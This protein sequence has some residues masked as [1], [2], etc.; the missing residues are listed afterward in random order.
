[1]LPDN[2][3]FQ[4]LKRLYDLGFS[5]SGMLDIGAY[6]GDFSRSARKI[7]PNSHIL[8]VEALAEKEKSL[9]KTCH[10]LGNADYAIALLGDEGRS[11]TS[12]FVVDVPNGVK[13]G[14][15]KFK[16]NNNY[17]LIERHLNQVTLQTLL[18]SRTTIFQFI[19]ID[20]QGAELD[21][22]KG[23]GHYLSTIDVILIELSLVNYNDGA[24]LIAKVLG[25]LDQMGFALFDLVEEHRFS[26]YL[27]QIDGLFLRPNCR[28]RPQPPFFG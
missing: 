22:L 18:N 8:M 27:F 26:G 19:K 12:F 6:D 20:V 15:S 24:P 23:M 21:V 7:F 4:S 11:A 17:P 25:V 10:E 28:Y 5:P 14:S 9:S 2:A 16:E 3:T 1:M 13:T